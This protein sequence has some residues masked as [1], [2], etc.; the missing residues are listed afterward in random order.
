MQGDGNLVLYYSDGTAAGTGTDVTS[1]SGGYVLL[2]TRY[3]LAHVLNSNL[4][5]YSARPM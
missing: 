4:K 1:P 3:P 2:Q 5:F